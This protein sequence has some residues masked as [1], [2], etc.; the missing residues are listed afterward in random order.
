MHALESLFKVFLEVGEGALERSAP[1]DQHVII[2]GARRP[3]RNEAQGGP[4]AA[5]DPVPRYGVTERLCDGKPEARSR[6]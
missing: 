5:P 6:Q 3:G 4:Q 1:R 2:S